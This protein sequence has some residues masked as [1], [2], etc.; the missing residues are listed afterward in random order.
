M[1]NL[2]FIINITNPSYIYN[3]RKIRKKGM[4]YLWAALTK[5]LLNKLWIVKYIKIG[6][7]AYRKCSKKTKPT[8]WNSDMKYLCFTDYKQNTS[9]YFYKKQWPSPMLFW[10]LC[11]HCDNLVTRGLGNKCVD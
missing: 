8:R 1:S 3:I 10:H 9:S 11:F 2:R 6:T 4:R 7:P 5:F